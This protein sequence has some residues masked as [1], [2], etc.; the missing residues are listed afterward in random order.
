M[1]QFVLGFL[2]G[3]FLLTNTQEDI[4]Q[5]WLHVLN[6]S[7]SCNGVPRVRPVP[8]HDRLLVA[9]LLEQ[10]EAYCRRTGTTMN[11]WVSDIRLNY[12]TKTYDFSS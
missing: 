11:E 9:T 10:A 4:V 12:K 6:Y 8:V 5:K 3:R 2:L 1:I 7:S